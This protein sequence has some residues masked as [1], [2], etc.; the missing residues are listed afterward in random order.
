MIERYQY[1]TTTSTYTYHTQTYT[2]WI[3]FFITTT[4]IFNLQANEFPQFFLTIDQ[5]ENI[6]QLTRDPN[7]N[8]DDDS[9]YIN[10]VRGIWKKLYD[11][12]EAGA[13]FDIPN[14]FANPAM[15]G[16]GDYDSGSDEM[17]IHPGTNFDYV[18]GTAGPAWDPEATSNPT[19]T[20]LLTP[21]AGGDKKKRKS[22]KK[23]LNKKSK[24]KNRK[25]RK[26]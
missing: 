21:A 16:H 26:F 7:Y 3:Q 6:L 18:Y 23:R 17:L 14:T 2:P 10:I 20:D 13:Y 4:Q 11:D 9:H 5:F 25:T 8:V 1:D 19:V 12:I 22:R 24:R 15:V